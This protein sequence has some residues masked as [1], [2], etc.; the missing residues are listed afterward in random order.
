ML[1]CFPS[2]PNICSKQMQKI[3]EAD[4]MYLE[5]AEGPVCWQIFKKDKRLVSIAWDGGEK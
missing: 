4:D 1:F 3:T 2:P 5:N